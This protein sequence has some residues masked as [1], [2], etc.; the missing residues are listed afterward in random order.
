VSM[1]WERAEQRF[2]HLS[3]LDA[4]A[5]FAAKRHPTRS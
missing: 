5:R 3:G 4:L 1:F 2:M